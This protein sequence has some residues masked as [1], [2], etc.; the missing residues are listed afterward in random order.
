MA[1]KYLQ[2]RVHALECKNMTENRQNFMGI[3]LETDPDSIDISAVVADAAQGVV[4]QAPTVFLGN[5]Y[6]DGKKEAWSTPKVIAEI[7]ITDTDVF[8]R[9]ISVVVN[10]AE[11]DDGAGFEELVTRVAG[12][13]ANT[14]ADEVGDELPEEIR[15]SAYYEQVEEVAE[16]VIAML[17]REIG[18]LLGLGDDPFRPVTL[19]HELRSLTDAP[20]GTRTIEL[21][22]PDRRH[23]G[24]FVL[25]YGWHL[26]DRASLPTSTRTDGAADMGSSRAALTGANGTGYPRGYRTFRFAPP[27]RKK[28]VRITVPTRPTAKRP[29]ARN[30][31]WLPTPVRFMGDKPGKPPIK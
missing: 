1:T 5:K 26:A 4:A 13:L 6:T 11:K 24:K 20:N 8:P 27:L 19:E 16:D 12:E 30:F 29:V 25:T 3:P 14:L 2:L 21:L 17:F 18:K 31:W 15:A 22:E 28:A 10:M 7:P 9:K 23:K